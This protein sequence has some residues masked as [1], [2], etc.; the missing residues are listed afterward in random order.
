[1]TLA[2]LICFYSSVLSSLRVLDASFKLGVILVSSLF[3]IEN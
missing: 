1:M 2:F 3:G